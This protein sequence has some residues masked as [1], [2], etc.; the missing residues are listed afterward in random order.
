MRRAFRASAAALALLALGGCAG[1]LDHLGKPPTMSSVADPRRPIDPS[2]PSG[3]RPTPLGLKDLGLGAKTAAPNAYPTASTPA[4][5]P[6]VSTSSLWSAG[7]K[8]L[9]GDRRAMKK[10]DILTVEIE[11][12]DSA[13]LTNATARNRTATDSVTATT[14]FGIDK[15]IDRIIPGDTV[16]LGQGV[17]TNG[18]S[19]FAGDGEI[20]RGETISLRL[21]AT[22]IEVLPNGYLVISGNQEVRVNFELGDLQVA[23]VIRPEDISRKNTISYDKIANAR[24]SYG[25][26]GDVSEVQQPR[27]GSQL[28]DLISPF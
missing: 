26:V 17:D 20:S 12:D 22:V 19:T 13:S 6:G 28:I 23:G 15:L 18:T 11:I 1:Q 3:N 5:T 4:P 24:V 10:G 2:L 8:S 25:G 14:V 16:G 9:F 7:P 21:A 27:I